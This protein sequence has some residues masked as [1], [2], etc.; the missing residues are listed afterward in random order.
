MSISLPPLAHP[1]TIL[2]PTSTHTAG[3][4]THVFASQIVSSLCGRPTAST[5]TSQGV[6]SSSSEKSK[7]NEKEKENG[8]ERGRKPI[9]TVSRLPLPSSSSLS[10]SEGGGGAGMGIPSS[11]VSNRNTLPKVGDIVLARVTR[12][13]IRQVDVGILFLM[14]GDGAGGARTGQDQDQGQG[15]DQQDERVI[16]GGEESSS[17]QSY[18]VNADAYPATIRREDVRATEV[19]KVVTSEMFRVGDLVRAVVISLGDQA[20]YYLSTAKNEFGVLMA[21]RSEVGG[22]VM[23]PV[24]WREFRDEVTGRKEGRKVAKP[25]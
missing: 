8:K 15:Q 18:I 13:R 14:E 6:F 4:G 5:T 11:C 25:F 10:S 1:G 3:P 22:N 19:E 2:A 21:R 17:S 9:V 12:V 23:V 7:V 16:S 24:S 20:N